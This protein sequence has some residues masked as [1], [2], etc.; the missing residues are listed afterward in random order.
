MCS[1]FTFP[2]IINRMVSVTLGSSLSI[3][4][5]I[6]IMY[7]CRVSGRVGKRSI[8]KNKQIQL[9]NVHNTLNINYKTTH[10]QLL[11]Y[12]LAHK[13]TQRKNKLYVSDH[14]HHKYLIIQRLT[15][16]YIVKKSTL[17][18]I[19]RLHRIKYLIYL[20]ANNFLLFTSVTYDFT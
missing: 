2:C 16:L 13:F 18:Y 3:G 8:L 14:S 1:L 20:N 10:N 6:S 19:T 7:Y 4:L 9:Y 12:L 11:S 15:L 5:S 17:Q